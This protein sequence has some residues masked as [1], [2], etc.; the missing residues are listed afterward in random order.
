MIVVMSVVVGFIV[1]SILLPIL[2]MS[3]I[4]ETLVNKHAQRA[5]E[6]GFTL[7]EMMVVIVIIGIL[8]GLRDQAA[9]RRRAEKAKVEATKAMI[10]CRSAQ[11]ARHVL[12][13]S[14]TGIRSS[15]RI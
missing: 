11:V 10:V 2:Q 7:V 4:W 12:S 1:L 15:S 13:W 3:N 8:A 6:P 9:R 5:A 14:S